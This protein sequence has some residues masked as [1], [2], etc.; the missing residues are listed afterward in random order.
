M[1]GFG[2]PSNSSGAF[3]APDSSPK[4]KSQR[5][6]VDAEA[7]NCARRFNLEFWNAWHSNSGSF[8]WQ[9]MK[10][11]TFGHGLISEEVGA[12]A[13][14]EQIR[15]WRE[16]PS[17]FDAS[18]WA[19]IRGLYYN[20]NRDFSHFTSRIDPGE[21]VLDWGCGVAYSLWHERDR[22]LDLTLAD[23]DSYSFEYCK[24]EF[25]DRASY[26]TLPSNLP[27]Q[28]FRWIIC[29]DVLEHIRRPTDTL[30]NLLDSLVPGGEILIWMEDSDQPG[31]VSGAE[32]PMVIRALSKRCRLKYRLPHQEVWIKLPEKGR[33]FSLGSLLSAIPRWRRGRTT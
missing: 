6:P 1:G 14:R 23:M 30:E 18:P 11:L 10:R 32:K 9:H 31:H 25:G 21:P 12:L 33:G 26:I 15:I 20:Q 4:G 8:P 19:V 17:D 5:G 22:E 29:L 13:R 27:R 7:R 16:A 24:E 3:T 28:W 2:H